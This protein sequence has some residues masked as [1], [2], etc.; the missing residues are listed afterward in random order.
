M[1]VY[2][3]RNPVS[4]YSSN[5]FLFQRIVHLPSWNPTLLPENY[6]Y[7]EFYTQVKQRN[8]KAWAS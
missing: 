3:E 5:S 8:L 6:Y 2:E 4:F 1:H 7:W